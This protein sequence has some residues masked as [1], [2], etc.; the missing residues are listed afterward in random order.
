MK[1]KGEF[2]IGTGA[3]SI[4]MILVVLSLTALA[5]LSFTS[6]RNNAALSK[7]NL[8][9]TV[10]YYNA[11]AELQRTIAGMDEIV[12]EQD[13]PYTDPPI[14]RTLLRDYLGA[15][16]TLADDMTF[17]LQSDAGAGR[18]LVVEG[19]LQPDAVQRIVLTRHELSAPATPQE[20]TGSPSVFMSTNP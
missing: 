3:S 10:A 14:W 7:R 13:S 18:T 17:T 20:E 6:A 4:L 15:D 19:I 11:A 2:R 5:L 1:N 9:M 16:D 8:D 12:M